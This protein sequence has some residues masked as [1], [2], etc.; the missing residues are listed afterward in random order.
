MNSSTTFLVSTFLSLTLCGTAA[1][2]HSTGTATRTQHSI[3]QRDRAPRPRPARGELRRFLRALQ[4]SD[5][6]KSVA[7]EQ[8]RAADPIA[9]SARVESAKI[10]AD[11]LR[12]HPG[13]RAGAREEMRGRM[14]E[15]RQRTLEQLR[16]FARTV[17]S[18]LTPEQ[19]TKL[20]EAAKKRGKTLDEDRLEKITSWLLTRPAV[21][22]RLERRTTR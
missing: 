12:D 2:Q 14:K 13:D 18:T 7:L 17:L 6:Q 21:R 20:A 16:P 11:A 5:A 22:G 4:L 3:A 15:L 9:H 1:A 19:R 8:A 10:R